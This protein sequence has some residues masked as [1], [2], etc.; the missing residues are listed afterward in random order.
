[1]YILKLE[2]PKLQMAIPCQTSTMDPTTMTC[3]IFTM[4]L[5]LPSSVDLLYVADGAK[6]G[7]CTQS[8]GTGKALT[9]VEKVCLQVFLF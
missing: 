8:G 9:N 4:G 2:I 3:E 1:V 7:K 6:P 5:R